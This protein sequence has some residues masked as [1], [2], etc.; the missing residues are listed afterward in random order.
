MNEPLRVLVAD[1][2]LLARK[3]LLRLLAAM[4]EVT[5]AG[6]CTDGHEVLERVRSNDVDLVLLDIEM[7]RL[8]GV[9]TLALLGEAGPMVVF[10]TA[11]PQHALAAF[12]NGAVDYLLKPIEPARLKRAIERARQRRKLP[13]TVMPETR[14]PAP[15][16]GDV[17]IALATRRGLEVIAA[18]DVI[19]ARVDGETVSVHTARGVFI[20]DGRI[21]ALADRLPAAGFMRVHRKVVLNLAHLVALRPVGASAY[22]AELTDGS[23]VPVARTIA[24][25]M[26][27]R[28]E[29]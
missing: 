16:A 27:A 28:W 12:D 23:I 4:P 2:E 6:E 29:V 1:D 8:S 26:R 18:S 25:S 24:R 5:I 11:H 3:R 10:A 9:E 17:R 15:A 20:T 13:V 14:D 21:Q 7:A 19:Y 22:E